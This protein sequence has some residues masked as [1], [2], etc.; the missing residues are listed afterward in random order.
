MTNDIV[1]IDTEDDVT[2]SFCLSVMQSKSHI[3][4]K[5]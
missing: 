4:T 1:Y 2:L 5:K 3:D